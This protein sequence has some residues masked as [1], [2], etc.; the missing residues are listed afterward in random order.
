MYHHQEKPDISELTNIYIISKS[1]EIKI[2]YNE[3][4]ISG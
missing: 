4:N 2:I 3:E 1:M